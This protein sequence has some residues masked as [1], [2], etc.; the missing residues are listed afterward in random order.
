[1]LSFNLI[2]AGKLTQDY[3]YLNIYDIFLQVTHQSVLVCTLIHGTNI[4]HTWGS[5]F[6][7]DCVF[8]SS[9]KH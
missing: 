2:S 4:E 6:D 5:K 1:M 3:I 9:G 8:M 7:L